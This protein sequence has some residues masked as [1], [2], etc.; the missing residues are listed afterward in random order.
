MGTGSSEHKIR[1]AKEKAV[2]GK[3]KRCVKGKS[4]SATC[5]ASNKV[6][7]VEIPWVAASGISKVSSMV[8]N[9]KPKSLSKEPRLPKLETGEDY[10]STLNSTYWSKSE[11]AKKAHSRVGNIIKGVS[12]ADVREREKVIKKVGGKPA[13]ERGLLSIKDFTSESYSPMR[14]VQLEE[15]GGKTFD[16]PK[17]KAMLQRVK[18]AEKL[19]AALPKDRVIKFRGISVDANQ[20]NA[21][22]MMAKE[23]G[24]FSDGALASW[25]TSLYEAD[26]FSK[27]GSTDFGKNQSVI[28]RAINTRGVAIDSISSIQGESEVL[29]SGEAKYKHT[30]NYRAIESKGWTYHIFDVIE[31]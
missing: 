29:T 21:M 16:D 10:T 5:I 7:L 8:K 1:S 22:R 6:C 30:G 23:K 4:C 25:S 20:L 14:E 31:S 28:F 13:L 9:R 18:D 11:E 3:R 24:S 2:G 15:K 19:I 26:F 27:K 17:Q 12:P